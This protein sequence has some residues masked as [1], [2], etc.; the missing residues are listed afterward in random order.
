VLV[1]EPSR[2]G[3]GCQQSDEA[4]KAAQPERYDGGARVQRDKQYA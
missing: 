4:K 1:G 2:K 3:V